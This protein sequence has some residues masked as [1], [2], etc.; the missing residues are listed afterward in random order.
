MP[1]CEW[2]KT[3]TCPYNPAHQITIER[4]Q[5]HLVKCRKQH[6]TSEFIVCPYNASHHVPKPE[7]QYHLQTCSDRKIVELARYK[8]SLDRPGQH[9][10]LSMPQ[11]SKEGQAWGRVVDNLD[12]ENWE[13]DATVKKSYD[14]SKKAA[15]SVVL[16]NKQ[17][18]TPSERKEFRAQ[19]RTRIE[20]LKSAREHDKV[21]REAAS[22]R[23]SMGLLGRRESVPSQQ[24][25]P[26]RRP[27]LQPRPAVQ[28]SSAAPQ[29]VTRALL[30]NLGRG[31][32]L[33]TSK[34]R[35]PGSILNLNTSRDVGQDLAGRNFTLDSS[36]DTFTSA[37]TEL[38]TSNAQ[39]GN[40]TAELQDR[41]LSL[42]QLGQQG[43]AG[44]TTR[45]RF[46]LLANRLQK[47]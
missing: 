11:P 20:M 47:R 46:S 31:K 24:Q 39:G 28:E 35:R 13:K 34:L 5:W 17:G 18:A 16:R 7:E 43:Q 30:A 37:G 6:N 40:R 14:P 41:R 8:L 25:Q 2:E 42:A 36:V 26:L 21:E 32:A 1:L 33:Q 15:N 38:E 45:E 10:N 27:S 12:G 44:N 22:P 23:P 9:G 19:E 3:V 29:S 4:I